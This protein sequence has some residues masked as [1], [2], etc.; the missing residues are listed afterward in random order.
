MKPPAQLVLTDRDLAILEMVFSYGGVSVHHIQR[1]FF[2]SPGARSSAY[3]RV[4][5]LVEAGYLAGHRL[6]SQTGQGSG[7]FFL[8]TGPAARPVLAKLLNCSVSALQRQT[9]AKAPATLNHELAI[10]DVRLALELAVEAS[11]VFTDLAWTS[12][13]EL[14]RRPVTVT[15]PVTQNAIPLIADGAFILTLND[16]SEQEF[17]LEIDMATL[18]AKRLRAKLRGYL[19]WAKPHPVPVLWAASSAE[20]ALLLVT[21]AAEEAKKLGADPTIFWVTTQASVNEQTVLAGR[22]WQVV[23]GPQAMTLGSLA[24]DSAGI[25]AGQHQAVGGP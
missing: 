21:L 9:R 25:G 1:R 16:H 6:P 4:N 14:R 23:G 22:I 19:V 2:R 24:G 12:E 20:R 17:L 7:K 8:L 15:D 10:I 11:T 3:D 13:W 18:A 5:R